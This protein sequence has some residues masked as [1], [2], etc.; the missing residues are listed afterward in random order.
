[1]GGGFALLYAVRAPLRAAGVF[2][3]DVPTTADELRGV[4]PV[5]AGYGGRD[6]LFAAQGERLERHLAALGVPHDVRVYPDAGHS[7]MSH[8]EGVLATLS[9]WGPMKVG[10]N[11]A[12]EADSWRRVESFFR[13]HLGR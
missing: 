11:A 1:M 10:W 13:E 9:A 4:C 12:A 2:Y 6:R 3:G 8:H 7:F 5:V